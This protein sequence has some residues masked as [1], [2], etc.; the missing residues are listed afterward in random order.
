VDKDQQ[1][2]IDNAEDAAPAETPAEGK[3]NQFAIWQCD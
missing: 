1:G 3:K 2:E